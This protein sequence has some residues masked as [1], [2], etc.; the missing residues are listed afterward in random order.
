MPTARC[1]LTTCWRGCTGGSCGAGGAEKRAPEDAEGAK[2]AAALRIGHTPLRT[3]PALA[4]VYA[5][6]H[7][8][9]YLLLTRFTDSTVPFWDAGT[10]A[11]SVVAMW[12][13]SR[14][15]VEQW[16][17][18]LV[19]DLVTVGLYLYKDL[20]YTA[21]LYALYSALAVAGYLRWRK[22]AAQETTGA[23]K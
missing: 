18:W 5:A 4:G 8:G 23:A 2:R 21:G 20:P 19:V 10:T 11:L 16:L 6:A 7:I 12:M 9:L 17:V 1:R 13:L 15:L 14:K 22:L 3:V